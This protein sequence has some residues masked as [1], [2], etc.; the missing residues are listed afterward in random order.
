MSGGDT[1]QRPSADGLGLWRSRSAGPSGLIGSCRQQSRDVPLKASIFNQVLQGSSSP[2]NNTICAGLPSDALDPGALQMQSS[3]TESSLP[4][5]TAPLRQ[6]DLRPIVMSE[7]S[8]ACRFFASRQIPVNLSR[9]NLL[10]TK[11]GRARCEPGRVF[12]SGSR[13]LL[14]LLSPS[15][16]RCPCPRCT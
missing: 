16:A 7:H 9:P 2:I 12:R 6:D 11:N 14:S 8:L 5:R 3:F 13:S 10:L 15:P 4:P 1:V